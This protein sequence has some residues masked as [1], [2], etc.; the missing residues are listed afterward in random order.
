VVLSLATA[1]DVDGR[2]LNVAGR[3]VKTLC[4]GK[5]FAAGLNSLLWNAMSDAGL[6]AP[7]GMCLI[8]VTARGADGSRSTALV[9][10]RIS[11]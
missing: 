4:C 11:R 6:A 2:V 1:A 9:S 5:P 3:P 7:N 10:V 8:E